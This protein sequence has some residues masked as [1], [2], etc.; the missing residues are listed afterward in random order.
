MLNTELNDRD[1]PHRTKIRS[2]TMEL[3]ELC[4]HDLGKEMRVT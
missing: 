3:W 2:Q 4:V 1:I